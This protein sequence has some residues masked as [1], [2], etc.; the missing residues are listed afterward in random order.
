MVK[1]TSTAQK[2]DRAVEVPVWTDNG[3]TNKS[4]GANKNGNDVVQLLEVMT[5][6]NIVLVEEEN[7]RYF[8]AVEVVEKRVIDS[9]KICTL[10]KQKKAVIFSVSMAI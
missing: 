8:Q 1:I 10:K 3:K 7:R 6:I 9:M 2:D 5:L 4:N